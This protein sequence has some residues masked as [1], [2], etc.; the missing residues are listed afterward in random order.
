MRSVAGKLA[1]AN[2]LPRMAAKRDPSSQ[3][4]AVEPTFGDVPRHQFQ[5]RSQLNLRRNV[6]WDS[7]L[8]YVSRPSHLAIP[9]YIRLDSRVGWRPGESF[10]I[11]LVGQNPLGPRRLEF[12]DA[13]RTIVHTELAVLGTERWRPAST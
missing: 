1:R 11:G 3:D 7:S 10:E 4:L 12:F 5:I 2:S 8:I 6:E 9:G 13:S